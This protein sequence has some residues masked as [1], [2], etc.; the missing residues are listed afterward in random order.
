MNRRPRLVH[1]T[2][3]AITQWQ[4]LRGQNSYMV[5]HGFDVHAIASP[6]PLLDQLGKRDGVTTHPLRISRQI[7]PIRDL[8][9]LIA[10]WRLLRALEPDIVH[11]STSKG[12]LLGAVA[13]RLAGVPIRIYQIRGLASE[14]ARGPQRRVFLALEWLTARLCNAWLANAPSLLAY[15]RKKGILRRRQGTVFLH[16]MANGIDV[17][18]FDPDGAE[19]ARPASL[20]WPAAVRDGRLVIGY[21]GRLTRDKGIEDLATAWF[22]LRETFPTSRLLLVGPWE[23]QDPVAHGTRA[24]LEA[25]ARVTILPFQEDVRPAYRSMDVFVYPSHGG[26]GFPNAPMEAAAM[27]LPVIVTRVIG[28]VDAVVDGCTGATVPPRD[29]TALCAEIAAYLQDAERRTA[30]GRAGRVRVKRDFRSQALWACVRDEYLRL[31]VNHG[32]PIPDLQRDASPTP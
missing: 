7:S 4:F 10:L 12:A 2:A 31:L 17:A 1:V 11:V 29:P 13:A 24:R 22:R 3:S 32:L 19:A 5:R 14:D 18:W 20:P 15:A 30:H 25:D 9:S 21:V 6:S 27:R 8:G 26:E 23:T 16:G 28:S